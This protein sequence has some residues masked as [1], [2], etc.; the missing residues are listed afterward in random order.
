MS[1]SYLFNVD[2][3]VSSKLFQLHF[4]FSNHSSELFDLAFS[5][6]HSFD[7]DFN[8]SLFFGEVFF[9][10]V[11]FY[12]LVIELTEQIAFLSVDYEHC[13]L[14]GLKFVHE[15]DGLFFEFGDAEAGLGKLVGK[16]VVFIFRLI[17]R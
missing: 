16:G 5:F 7:F 11:N 10:S 2:I 13:F 3:L 12:Q 4:Q 17:Q 9:K 1:F 6:D 15:G 8:H 14:T